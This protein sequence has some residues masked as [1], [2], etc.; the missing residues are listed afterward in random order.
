MRERRSER[1]R[2]CPSPDF[3]SPILAERVDGPAGQRIIGGEQPDVGLQ[4]TES[5]IGQQRQRATEALDDRTALHALGRYA[6]IVPRGDGNELTL[7]DPLPHFVGA[8][9]Q[10]IGHFAHRL[11]CCDKF[12]EFIHAQSVTRAEGEHLPRGSIP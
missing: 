1:K 11:P 7:A 2:L 6:V 4:V 3:A 10:R 5:D 9:V 8:R 12:F